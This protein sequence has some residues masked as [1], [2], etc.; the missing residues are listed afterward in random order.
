[1][2][3]ARLITA[4][5]EA[6]DQQTATAEVLGAINASPGNLTP[7]FD[8]MLETAM[9]LT[10]TVAG[11]LMTYDGGS[12]TAVAARGGALETGGSMRP[13]AGYVL[14]RLVQGAPERSCSRVSARRAKMRL[15]STATRANSITIPRT[16]TMKRNC[17]RISTTRNTSRYPT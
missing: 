3:N 4:T 2:E 10:G 15:T 7:V 16:A 13:Q 11:H 9:R 12:F 17:L 5:Q 6:L 1:M 8:A 14:E